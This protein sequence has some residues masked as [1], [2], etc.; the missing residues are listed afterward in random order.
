M[1]I[2]TEYDLHILFYGEIEVNGYKKN[3]K[4]LFFF[5]YFFYIVLRN[6]LIILKTKKKL[7]KIIIF[8]SLTNYKI[9]FL[10]EELFEY[11]KLDG[12]E[13]SSIQIIFLKNILNGFSQKDRSIF[14]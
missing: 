7:I 3:K 10:V 8:I 12:Y 2:L 1:S 9:F 6:E 5:I 14:L 11:A 4:K 13:N